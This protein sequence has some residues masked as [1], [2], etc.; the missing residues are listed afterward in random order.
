MRRP[1]FGT[2][3]AL[4]AT[5]AACASP[6]L[7][8]PHTGTPSPSVS[9]ISSS[10]AEPPSADDL[11][12][13]LVTADDFPSGWSAGQTSRSDGSVANSSPVSG[14]ATLTDQSVVS[15]VERDFTKDSE[16]GQFA[17]EAL[18]T[19]TP[20]MISTA[21]KANAAIPESCQDFQ[22]SISGT[23]VRYHVRRL[24]MS[25]LGTEASA[26]EL[27]G[28]IRGTII[29]IFARKADVMMMLVMSGR[30]ADRALSENVAG[31]ALANLR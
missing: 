13:Q 14:C 31:K 26:M 23:M 19:G 3:V 7:A 18:F 9:V 17:A 20:E 1:L 15:S 21:F 11:Q 28:D 27:S 29:V 6:Q 22:K 12:S 16:A 8:P 10:A 24:T 25:T 4:F 5:S 2:L 30:P